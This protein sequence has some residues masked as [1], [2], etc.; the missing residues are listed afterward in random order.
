MGI[1]SRLR[2]VF[3]RSKKSE[4]P[5]QGA[6]GESP[7]VAEGAEAAESATE[8]ATPAA[9]ATAPAAATATATAETSAPAPAPASTSGEPSSKDTSTDSGSADGSAPS[10]TAS[11]TTTS[12]TTASGTDEDTDAGVRLP[13]QS[14]AD[15]LVSAAFDRVSVPR[16]AE[17]VR[18]PSPV[19]PAQ[20]A[21]PAASAVPA[22]SSESAA[23]AAATAPTASVTEVEAKPVI[24][25]PATEPDPTPAP[26]AETVA[27]P[28]AEPVVT[29]AAPTIPA[30]AEP[31]TAPVTAPVAAPEPEAVP[32]PQVVV[33]AEPAAAPEPAAEPVPAGKPAWSLARVRTRAPG[34]VTG[35][36]AAGA[37]LR[38]RDLT[39]TRLRVYLVLDRSGSMRGYY[40]DGSAQGLGEQALALSAHL[41]ETATVPVVLFSTEVDGTGE[42]DL[43][44]YEGRVDELHAAAGRMGRTSYPAAIAEV[45]A[46]YEKSGSEDPALV[47]F[48]VDG[49]PDAKGPATEALAE[50]ARLPLFFQFVA[51]GEHEAKGFDY[52]RKLTADNAAFYHAGPA[53]RELTDKELYDGLLAALPDWLAARRG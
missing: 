49:P 38:K 2:G 45:V 11:G 36:K 30:P 41:D 33:E 47:V 1:L 18:D 6:E 4:G 32:E 20:P 50:A 51:F 52:L 5:A 24:P 53:P 34:L 39:G 8:S 14:S 7:Q 17:P 28:A 12:G 21:A 15:E 40:K 44:A 23:P 16:P 9:T 29:E 3:G 31:I 13:A 43:T 48:Q 42:L 10:D 22:T 46:H 37:A 26:V 25:A 19:V 35:Y 27:A